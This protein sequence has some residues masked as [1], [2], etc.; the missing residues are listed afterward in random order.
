MPPARDPRL[1]MEL[2]KLLMQVAWA[3]GVVDEQ[4]SVRVFDHAKR[5]KL[6]PNALDLLWQCLQ[7]KRKLPA[8]DL[9]FLR[10]HADVACDLAEGLVHADGQVT[11]EEVEV[12][13]QIE[14]M[15]RG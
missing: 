10:Q 13:A 9:G 11:E 12:L 3:D 1:E 15:L 6:Q 7:G 4:E 14:S 5:L 2:I 8:P